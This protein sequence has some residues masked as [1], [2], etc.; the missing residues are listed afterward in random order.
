MSDLFVPCPILP[1]LL[2]RTRKLVG[3]SPDAEALLSDTLFA[4]AGGGSV[5]LDMADP[6]QT[7]SYIIDV[8]RGSSPD[9]IRRLVLLSRSICSRPRRKCLRSGIYLYLHFP[10][11]PLGL[12]DG[13]GAGG[14]VG[15]GVGVIDG[16]GGGGGVGVGIGVGVIEPIRDKPIA[17]SSM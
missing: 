10:L 11:L 15:V 4:E 12:H 1:F 7:S 2:Q 6:A 5:V 14:G 9:R 13:G 8:D 3:D 17:A 16:G